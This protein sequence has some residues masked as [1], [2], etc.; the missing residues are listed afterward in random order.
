MI[1]CLKQKNEQNI[2]SQVSLTRMINNMEAALLPD[3]RT[4][5]VSTNNLGHGWAYQTLAN[6]QPSSELA[7][8]RA[9]IGCQPRSCSR[10]V[11]TKAVRWT[12]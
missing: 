2:Y 3:E 9:V 4:D 6:Q 5:F 12:Q 10:L 11:E 7:A 1:P 8:R